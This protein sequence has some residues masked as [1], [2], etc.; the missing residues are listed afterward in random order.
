MRRVIDLTGKSFGR[1]VVIDRGQRRQQFN[2][3]FR[4][5]WVCKCLCGNIKEVPSFDLRNGFSKSCGCYQKE[6]AISDNTTHGLSKTVEYAHWTDIHQRCYNKNHPRYKDWGGR[7]IEVCPRWHKENSGGFKN[8]YNDV[9]LLGSSPD[10][11]FTIDR[12]DNN[13][14]YSPDNI[15]WASKKE[16][17]LNQQNHRVRILTYKN[18]SLCMKEWAKKI[19]I[20]P[21]N[22]LYWLKKGKSFD[23]IYN[24]YMNMERKK[25]K[26]E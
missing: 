1:W 11:T 25:D 9:K 7:G 14:N 13:K 21:S 19:S 22:I 16:Q 8:Y 6:K 3:T 10:V 2:G 15:R 17:R 23:W 18:E 12:I 4:T 5:T 20:H 26:D 24:N